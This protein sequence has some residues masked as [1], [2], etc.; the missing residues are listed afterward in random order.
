MLAALL[1]VPA[2]ISAQGHDHA[3]HSEHAG[4]QGREIKALDPAA[5]DEYRAGAGMGLALAAELNS[6]PG[7]RHVLELAAELKLTDAQRAATQQAREQMQKQ[8]V[9]L[10]E[11]IIELE[12]ELDRRFAHR[13]IDDAVLNDLTERIGVLN[14]RLRAVHL[15]AHLEVTALLT[16]EQVKQYDRLRGYD[17]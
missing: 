15:R 17:G 3:V 16:D 4:K 10:G 6:Y 1:L 5:I 14:G 8:A 12:R 2:T 11:Q 7:P 13:H 9:A